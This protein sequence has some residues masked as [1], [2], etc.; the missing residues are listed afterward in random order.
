MQFGPS[1]TY[2]YTESFLATLRET[3]PGNKTECRLYTQDVIARGVYFDFTR[4]RPDQFAAAG[5]PG[6]G[7]AGC[8]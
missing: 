7:A 3:E 8:S 2:T 1:L 6:G 4:S 5:S